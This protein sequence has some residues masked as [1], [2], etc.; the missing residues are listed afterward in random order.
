MIYCWDT[1]TGKVLHRLVGHSDWLYFIAVSPDGQT[2]FSADRE[3][4]VH[5]WDLA[6][7]KELQCFRVN[8][9]CFHVAISPDGKMLAAEH[10]E[11]QAGRLYDLDMGKEVGRFGAASHVIFLPDGK[12][13]VLKVPGQGLVR[14][15]IATNKPG[16]WLPGDN[17]DSWSMAVSP[18]GK[19]FASGTSH[20]GGLDRWN[21]S[22]NEQLSSLDGQQKSIDSVAFSPDGKILASGGRDGTI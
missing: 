4:F 16:A 8:K 19:N 12:T 11:Q 5:R 20:H 10:G 7:A 21:L 3:D 14:W 15:D 13:L 17:V 1:E 9:D 22:T 18:D 6:K 2:L